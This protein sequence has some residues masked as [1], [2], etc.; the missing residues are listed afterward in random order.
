MEKKTIIIFMN[1]MKTQNILC[2]ITKTI[3]KK[4]G[5][6]TIIM[7]TS[8]DVLITD[9]INNSNSRMTVKCPYINQNSNDELYNVTHNYIKRKEPNTTCYVW[10]DKQHTRNCLQMIIGTEYVNS[11]KNKF[12][13]IKIDWKTL[14]DVTFDII[15]NSKTQLSKSNISKILNESFPFFVDKFGY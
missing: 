15:T 10:P 5:I 6:M 13:T 4:T 7:V 2:I 8:L 1:V 3:I 11:E 14:S 9:K 12:K